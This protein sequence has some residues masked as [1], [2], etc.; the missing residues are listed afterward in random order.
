M[1]ADM[2]IDMRAHTRADMHAIAVPL[3]FKGDVTWRVTI[4]SF[5]VN[6]YGDSLRDAPDQCRGY[7][8]AT[9]RAPT[10]QHGTAR[11][12]AGTR[13]CVRMQG[14]RLHPPEHYGEER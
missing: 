6:D 14:V 3:D 8:H 5:G 7:K 13:A 2:Y 4:P 1:C 12:H 10:A 9:A 11:M